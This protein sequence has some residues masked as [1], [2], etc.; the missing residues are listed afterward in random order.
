MKTSP[1]SAALSGSSAACTVC[2]HHSGNRLL[3]ESFASK[4]LAESR[5]DGLTL[6]HHKQ[7]YW[8]SESSDDKVP[9]VT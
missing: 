7:T 9:E 2:L 3:V 6:S 4:D 1:L 5:I 8:I